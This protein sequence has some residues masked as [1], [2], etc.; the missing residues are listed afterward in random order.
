MNSSKQIKSI[1]DQ[2]LNLEKIGIIY[3][4]EHENADAVA[5]KLLEAFSSHGYTAEQYEIRPKEHIFTD[6]LSKE[7]TFALV[8]GGDGTI[9][10]TAR[11][12][13][14]LEIPIMGINTGRLG[15]LA[16][17]N[18]ED[19]QYGIEKILQ[20]KFRIE[21]RLML[22]AFSESEGPEHTFNAL[23]DIVIKSGTIS[24]AA[25]LFLY[26]NNSHVCDYIADGLIISTPTGSTAYTLSAGGP[27]LVP[28]MNAI[29]IVPICPH[30]LTTRPL[31]IPADSEI[32]VK[33]QSDAETAY[34]TADGQENTKIQ[35]TDR[36][37]IKQNSFKAR[38]VMLDSS[39]GGF[40]CI[41][42]EKLHWGITPGSCSL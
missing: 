19:I 5:K 38:L 7:I 25:D 6:G 36:I 28:Q 41:L 15:F 14:P 29:V 17:L 18:P 35:I 20:G 8:I 3:N 9:L 11:H 26:V 42:R 31:V 39:H 13:A 23:N 22:K 34:M 37:Y 24:R 32:M 4:S 16:Q 1:D 30:A 21:E 40:Y 27:V 12:Y 33:I 10:S 2:A